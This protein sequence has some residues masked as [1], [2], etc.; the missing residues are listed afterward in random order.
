MAAARFTRDSRASEKK[1]TEPVSQAAR[2]FK[3]IVAT[4]AAMDSIIK[5]SKMRCSELKEDKAYY[6][7]FGNQNQSEGLVRIKGIDAEWPGF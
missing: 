3:I 6:S 1:P 4:A 2:D 5:R 7:P